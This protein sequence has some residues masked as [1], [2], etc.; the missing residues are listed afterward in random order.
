[1]VNAQPG[2][3]GDA[4]KC[5]PLMCNVCMFFEKGLKLFSERTLSQGSGGNFWVTLMST[6]TR[7]I[8]PG[9]ITGVHA[10]V[11]ECMQTHQQHKIVQL[12]RS[13]TPHTPHT[14]T[15][16]PKKL[17]Y[18]ESICIYIYIIYKYIYIY[19]IYTCIPPLRK[20][21]MTHSCSKQV[22]KHKR[23]LDKHQPSPVFGRIIE[24]GHE[25]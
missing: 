5:I 16:I 25:S 8:G 10:H 17:L 11:L 7:E 20:I 12:V 9:P 21:R 1:M 14:Y 2:F 19:K 24:R 6:S 13:H 23:L 22:R 4:F 18:W 15:M 3:P